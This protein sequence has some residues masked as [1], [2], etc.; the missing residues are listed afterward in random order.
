MYQFLGGHSKAWLVVSVVPFLIGSKV[1]V[2][3]RRSV[4]RLRLG[5]RLLFS[6]LAF[7]DLAGAMVGEII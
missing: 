4:G 7:G 6:L 3:G 2:R 5:R 1:D